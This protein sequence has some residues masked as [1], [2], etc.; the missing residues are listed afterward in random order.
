[1]PERF[2]GENGLRT[3]ARQSAGRGLLAPEIA[4]D[5][6]SRTSPHPFA[7]TQARRG[8]CVAGN[9]RSDLTTDSPARDQARFIV[10]SRID[11]MRHMSHIFP[12][13]VSRASFR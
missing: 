1:M 13:C 5:A 11:N 2:I 7:P 9:V 6:V 10:G 3:C 4:P 12:D 8:T